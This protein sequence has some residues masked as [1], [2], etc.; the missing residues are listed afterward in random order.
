MTSAALFPPNP[1]EL[2]STV[3]TGLRSGADTGVSFSCG[4]TFVSPAFAG[5]NPSFTAR[6][7]TTASMAPAAA[8]LCPV[9]PL[10]E[11]R[12]GGCSPKSDRRAR[13]SA[14]SLSTVPVP[15]RL[16]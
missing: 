3:A 8:R 6:A 4:S 14:R 2:E 7:D 1:K 9:A 13:A 16:T 12:G 15:C 5:T 10:I 11:E